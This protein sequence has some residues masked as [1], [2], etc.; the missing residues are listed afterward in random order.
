MT[1]VAFVYIVANSDFIAGADLLNLCAKMDVSSVVVQFSSRIITLHHVFKLMYLNLRFAS[2]VS[3]MRSAEQVLVLIYPLYKR[4][5]AKYS[6][7]LEQI[8][9]EELV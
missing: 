4:H 5:K 7:A 6:R 2:I 1:R 9:K 8:R 3:V